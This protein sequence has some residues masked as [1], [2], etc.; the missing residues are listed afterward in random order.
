MYYD[1]YLQRKLKLKLSNIDSCIQAKQDTF[2]FG[3]ADFIYI[4][5]SVELDSAKKHSSDNRSLSTIVVNK[6]CD[7]MVLEIQDSSISTDLFRF[8]Y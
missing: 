8:F 1:I 4:Y 6:G 7:K 3:D 2:P 5:V